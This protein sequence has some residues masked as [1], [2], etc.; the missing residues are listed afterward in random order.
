MEVEDAERDL[1]GEWM[2]NSAEFFVSPECWWRCM[3]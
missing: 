3:R 1:A 2:D